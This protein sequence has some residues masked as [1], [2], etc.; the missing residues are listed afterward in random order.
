MNSKVYVQSPISTDCT[1]RR[2]WLKVAS[3][4]R[5]LVKGEVPRFSANFSRPSLVWVTLKV[6]RYIVLALGIDKVVAMSD[7]NIHGTEIDTDMDTDKDRD[8]DR[9]WSGTRVETRTE[10]ETRTLTRTLTRTPPWT[11]RR[12]RAWNWQSF[13]Q[14]PCG[15]TFSIAPCE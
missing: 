11:R 1:T 3:T 12:T 5:S 7:I 13:T 4:D 9:T 14:D 2:I 15:L 8:W 6:P 10:T